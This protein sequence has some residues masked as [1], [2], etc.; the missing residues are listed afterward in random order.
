[1]NNK[2]PWLRIGEDIWYASSLQRFSGV[3]WQR[4]GVGL[5]I[6][7]I[8]MRQY[9]DLPT[10][11]VNSLVSGQYGLGVGIYTGPDCISGSL[12][13]ILYRGPCVPL[14]FVTRED[15]VANYEAWSCLLAA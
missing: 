15:R 14:P 6:A 3:L 5:V 9:K 7:S 11:W 8:S 4:A 1:M 13:F 12:S 2:T 10:F